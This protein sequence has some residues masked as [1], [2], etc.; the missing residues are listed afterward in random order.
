M[1]RAQ[2]ASDQELLHRFTNDKD[3]QAFAALFRRHAPMVLKVCRQ[4]LGN[5]HDAD[6]AFQATFLVLVRKARSL[7]RPEL[8]GNWLYGVARRTA[9]KAK[10]LI[11]RRRFWERQA[12]VAV[13]ARH[14]GKEDGREATTL[15][16][17]FERLPAQFRFPLALCYL[18]GLT[19]VEAARR[20]GIPP[21]TITN[22]LA[23]GRQLLRQGR[24]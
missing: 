5:A 6:D 7:V 13:N 9:W 23:R 16:E 2:D 8:L 17:G 20:L 19:N 1:V 22:R 14:G 11:A 18:E 10:V 21:G 4:M 3:K 24:C 15:P 12:A